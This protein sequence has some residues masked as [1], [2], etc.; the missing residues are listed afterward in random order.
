MIAIENV[1][2][3]G[4]LSGSLGATVT[5]TV[6]LTSTLILIATRSLS[7]R[8][9]S[10]WSVIV[11]AI[12]RADCMRDRG[13]LCSHHCLDLCFV[14]GIGAC[15]GVLRGCGV[16][17]VV[18]LAMDRECVLVLSPAL[19]LNLGSCAQHCRRFACAAWRAGQKSFPR[20]Q[21]PTWW[22]DPRVALWN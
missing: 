17:C 19:A 5:V 14:T 1:I 8:P 15:H 20:A 3:S 18:W 11:I 4:T 22:C 12:S 13:S 16:G 6:T 7:A 9:P 2:W 10:T 21:D